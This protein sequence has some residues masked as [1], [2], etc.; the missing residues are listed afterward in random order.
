MGNK[1][2]GNGT[3]AES[4]STFLIGNRER[5]L[6]IVLLGSHLGKREANVGDYYEREEECCEALTQ[7]N[8]SLSSHSCFKFTSLSPT[9]NLFHRS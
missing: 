2:I 8:C 3:P 1:D 7:S 9:A 6:W 4:Y 5:E